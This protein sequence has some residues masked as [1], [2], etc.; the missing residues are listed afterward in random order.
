MDFK[1][2]LEQWEASPEGKKAAGN[3]RFSHILREKEAGLHHGKT[4]KTRKGYLTGKA[5][6]GRLKAM[7][8]QAEIDLHGLTG[9]EARIMVLE[10]LQESINQRLQKVGIVHGRGLHS[11]DGKSVLRDVVREVL[12][13]SPYVR[14][15]ENP[16]PV[17]GGSGAVWVILQRG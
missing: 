12:Q 8:P 1:D 10:F 5:S 3:G 4:H 16:P 14:S 9:E 13:K 2:I 7:R 17:E 15:Y 6:L 11:I